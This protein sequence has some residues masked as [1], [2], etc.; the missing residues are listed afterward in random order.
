MFQSSEDIRSYLR[1]NSYVLAPMVD[2]SDHPFRM[3]CRKYGAGLCFTPMV[4]AKL[5]LYDNSYFNRIFHSSQMDRPLVLQLAGPD[6]QTVFDCAM[7]FIQKYP[8]DIVDL[9]LGCPQQI[10]KRGNY[11][12]FLLEQEELVCKIVE[13]CVHLPVPF[14][15]KIR[16]FEERERSY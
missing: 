13:K 9:N 1:N 4:N 3:L 2:H 5:A 15:V 16:L 12:S 10:A 14:S 7:K 11:G 8:I 6:P